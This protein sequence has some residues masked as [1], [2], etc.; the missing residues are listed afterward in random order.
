[1]EAVFKRF[2][3]KR[4]KRLDPFQLRQAM[5]AMGVTLG[6]SRR[7]ITR[8][9]RICL[10]PF[11]FRCLLAPRVCSFADDPQLAVLLDIFDTDG[12]GFLSSSEFLYLFIDREALVKQWQDSVA[13]QKGSGGNGSPLRIDGAWPAC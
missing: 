11:E 6:L 12:D 10:V 2:E 1:M 4:E 3:D 5:K 7:Q 13:P 8:H 9:T